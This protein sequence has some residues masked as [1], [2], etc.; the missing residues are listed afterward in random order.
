M[1][2]IIFKSLS[3]VKPRVEYIFPNIEIKTIFSEN[4]LTIIFY[5]EKIE[6]T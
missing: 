3:E 5:P 4:K 6:S 1:D 2:R